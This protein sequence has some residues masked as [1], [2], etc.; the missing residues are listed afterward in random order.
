MTE[1]S[2]RG[3]QQPDPSALPEDR[4]EAWLAVSLWSDDQL[5]AAISTLRDLRPNLTTQQRSSLAFLQAVRDFRTGNGPRPDGVH[6]RWW[7]R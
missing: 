7:T 2:D 6:H 3:L 4:T 5:T 1:T